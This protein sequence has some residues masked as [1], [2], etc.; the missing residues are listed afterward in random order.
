MINDKH[1]I[2]DMVLTVGWI[3]GKLEVLA[4]LT[5]G[6]VKQELLNAKSN[7]ANLADDLICT[8]EDEDAHDETVTVVK[9]TGI[10][11][12][13]NIEQY[14]RKFSEQLPGRVVV[15]DNRVENIY[16]MTRSDV[17]RLV[18]ALGDTDDGVTRDARV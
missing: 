1:G 7:L 3:E 9:L 13:E 10:H 12:K 8:L 15:V 6:K 4:S 11:S 2:M 5:D 17:E 14:A 16:E 18:M